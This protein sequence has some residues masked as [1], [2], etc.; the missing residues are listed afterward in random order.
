[1][2]VQK[3]RVRR[4]QIG[5][6]FGM[7]KKGFTL[8]EIL[9]AIAL[10]VIMATILVPNLGRQIPG[11]ERRQII[12]QLNALTRL[13]WHNAIIT[14]KIHKVVF[15]TEKNNVHLEIAQD[16]YN[17]QGEPLFKPL[18]EAYVKASIY[19]P[20]RFQIKNFFIEGFDE[21]NRFGGGRKTTQTWFFIVPE[22]LAQEVTINLLDTREMV[23][24]KPQQI[25]L[26]LNPFTAQFNVYE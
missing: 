15:N 12:S 17:E 6:A 10:I 11:Y 14:N 9:V 16:T 13:A 21:M 26:V 1:M 20:D 25:G 24:N 8:L 4:K 5:L 19:W 2:E 7:N 18:K 22:G 23:D 3:V